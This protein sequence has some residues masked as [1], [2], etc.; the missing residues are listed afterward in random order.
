MKMQRGAVNS[1]KTLRSAHFQEFVLQ[2]LLHPSQ[3]L[4]GGAVYALA[5]LALKNE[6]FFYLLA[7]LRKALRREG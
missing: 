1:L 3:I 6:S 2:F 7:M 5:N 4:L